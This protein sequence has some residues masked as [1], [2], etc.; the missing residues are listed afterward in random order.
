MSESVVVPAVGMGLMGDQ[1]VTAV[2]A[3]HWKF[4]SGG[5]FSVPT[6]GRCGTNYW[7]I[8]HACYH[9]GSL[10]WSWQPVGATGRVFTYTW[11]DEPTH[12]TDTLENLAV[13]QLD[14]TAG[15]EP[16]R[17]SGWVEGVDKE[18]LVCDL[19]VEVAFRPVTDDVSVP[20]WRPQA[21]GP[22]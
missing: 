15:P 14:E 11:C 4:A 17:V 6:C 20:F 12:P 13:I 21:D 8:T 5:R 10:D 19:P 9:C 2:T 1:P 18:T 16:V 3:P 22:G 7:P